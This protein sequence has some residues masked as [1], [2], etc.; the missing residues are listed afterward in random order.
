MTSVRSLLAMAAT[1]L[2][3]ACDAPQV[4]PV[5]PGSDA[6]SIVEP[7]SYLLATSAL[8][9][10]QPSDCVG[11]G[12]FVGL[13]ISSF[14]T[15]THEADG[16]VV[17]SATAADGDV[18]LRIALAGT[19]FGVP[20]TS[21]VARGT[22]IDRRAEKTLGVVTMTFS[23][24]AVAHSSLTGWVYTKPEPNLSGDATGQFAVSS[25]LGQGRCGYAQ[26]TVR[27]PSF[28]EANNMQC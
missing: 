12:T 24:S 19:K 7:G 4:A 23:G 13:A 21:G 11:S 16:W 15:V 25:S 22:A 28:C 17:R 20:R 10:F 14:V 3:T 18:E 6:L 5:A 27:K 9:A 2:V 26:W 1:L 8:D